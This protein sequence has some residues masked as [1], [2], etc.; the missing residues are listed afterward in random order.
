MK[1]SKPVLISGIIFAVILLTIF[2]FNKTND[3]PGQYDD[4]AKC[5][6]D[7]GVKMYGAYWCPHCMSQKRMFG[8]SWKHINYIEC[9]LPNKS[10]QTLNCRQA[11]IR[12][13]PTW[14]FQD[15]KRIE[16]TLSFDKLSQYSNCKVEE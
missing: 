5:L 8:N 15:G 9:S 12:S 2:V 6:S 16:G 3:N 4:F 11:G 7:K 10:G 1:I 14:E 13:Y